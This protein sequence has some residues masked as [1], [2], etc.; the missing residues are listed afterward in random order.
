MR[1]AEEDGDPVA[2]PEPTYPLRGLAG[3]GRLSRYWVTPSPAS[4]GHLTGAEP[5]MHRVREV[6]E[7]TS[8]EKRTGRK[9]GQ[10]DLSWPSLR[11]GVAGDWKNLFTREAA[12]LFDR[13]AGETLVEDGYEPD[14]SWVERVPEHPAA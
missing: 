13:Y 8:F 3:Y 7:A 1:S 5:D 14:R 2:T 11:K 10:Q 9:R 12:E 6:L 4:C